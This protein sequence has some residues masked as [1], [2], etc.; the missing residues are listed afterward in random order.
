MLSHPAILAGDAGS[1]TQS[2]ALL[3]EQSVTTV[4]GTVGDNLTGLREVADVLLL[5]VA[6]PGHVFLTGLQGSSHRVQAGH[7]VAVAVTLGIAAAVELV[8]KTLENL[9]THDGH[10]AHVGHHI[11]GVGN[12]DTDLGQGGIQRAHAEG[13]D[14]HGTAL[15]GT[16]EVGVEDGAHLSRG[17][18]VVG[19]TGVLLLLG[20][21]ERTLL[22]ASH[23]RRSRT[24]QEAAGALLGVQANVGAF[25][26]QHVAQ[27]GV[28]FL[29]TV[30]PVDGIGFAELADLLH[31]LGSLLVS[32]TSNFHGAHKISCY[33]QTCNTKIAL[34]PPCGKKS[35]ASR[36]TPAHF[37]AKKDRASS[38][39]FPLL[40]ESATFGVQSCLTKLSI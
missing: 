3:A 8:L 40:G 5:V 11:S 17:L 13:D 28:L 23:V 26:N 27:L 37:G 25:L 15:H 36:H 2:Q 10:D 9:L 24:S 35:P 38:G 30:A 18:P 4:T 14:V 39:K 12:L 22:N 6:G 16:I 33:E 1:D 29:G 7:E 21:D 34:F 19:G 32:C 31:P 20:A